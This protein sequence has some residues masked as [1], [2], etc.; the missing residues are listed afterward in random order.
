MF[1]STAALVACGGRGLVAPALPGSALA[2]EA[3]PF[4]ELD[5]ETLAADSLDPAELR[6][7][8]NGAGFAG[9]S[10][11]VWIDA[12]QERRALVRALAF[13][14]PAG[15]DVYLGW[16]RAHTFDVI[17][18]AEEHA[19]LD[20]PSPSFLT[21][22]EPGGCCPKEGRIFLTAWREGTVVLSLEVG[23][24]NVGRRDA[25]EFASALDAAV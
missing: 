1:L 21:V 4:L 10:Q 22:H 3:G 20:V 6:A 16:L 17:G 12:E 5:A 25:Q 23:G 8:L 9:A 18:E 13:D 11:R 19:P 7:V 15:A 14:T 24:R 2:G